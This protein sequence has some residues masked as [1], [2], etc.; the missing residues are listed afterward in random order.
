MLRRGPLFL[1]LIK[2]KK[3]TSEKRFP[4]QFCSL[5]SEPRRTHAGE[6]AHPVLTGGA[7]AAGLRGTLVHVDLAVGALETRH[8]EAR[9]AVPARPAYGAV[10]AR[11]RRALVLCGGRPV[12]RDT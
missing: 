7:V 10:L 9:V 3:K 12:R 1:P 5:T 4:A 11:V 6:V 8:A 2:K